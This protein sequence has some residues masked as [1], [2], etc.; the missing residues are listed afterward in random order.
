MSETRTAPFLGRPRALVAM[1]HVAALP[2]TPHG[3]L[4]VAGIA[5]QAADE[6]RSLA[7]AGFDAI[8]IENMHDTPYLLRE[9]GPEIVAAMTAAAC[10]VRAAV[11][12]PI[13][14]QVLAG[15]NVA[16]VAIAHAAGLQFVR[17]EG[18]AFAAVADEGLIARADAGPLLRYRKAIGAEAVAIVADLKKKHSSHAITADVDLAETAAAAEF[19]GADAVVVTGTAT[20][21]ATSADDL[22]AARRGCR[23]PVL[24]GSGANAATV[25][26]LLDRADAVIVGS[27]LKKDGHWRNAPDPRRVEAFVRAARGG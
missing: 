9:V 25:A 5:R 4:P 8:L 17:A 16:A 12:V 2:G 19:L 24:V 13:G 23:L 20:G 21:K 11:D 27:D 7:E 18:F 15:A 22:A 26:G 1:V 14:I 3:G 10:A 6:A